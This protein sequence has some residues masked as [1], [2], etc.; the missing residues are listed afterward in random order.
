VRERRVAPTHE[1]LVLAE[2]ETTYVRR[3]R[4]LQIWTDTRSWSSQ[5]F[6]S[7]MSSGSPATAEESPTWHR[8]RRGRP[9]ALS[10]D[11]QVLP[12]IPLIQRVFGNRHDRADLLLF[13]GDY[14]S[15]RASAAGPATQAWAHLRGP[16]KAVER[17]AVLVSCVAVDEPD[18]PQLERIVRVPGYQKRG[19]DCRVWPLALRGR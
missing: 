10:P 7:S 19:E 16:V 15:A 17:I 12:L 4:D 9:D 11:C 5:Y 2:A 1:L 6:E 18:R 14:R 8:G 3:W 13:L